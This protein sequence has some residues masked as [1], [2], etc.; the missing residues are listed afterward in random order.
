MSIH[1]K[2]TS[3]SGFSVKPSLGM[4][5]DDYFR[6]IPVFI[7]GESRKGL[8]A[9]KMSVKFD[10]N[11]VYEYIDVKLIKPLYTK[12]FRY[13]TKCLFKAIEKIYDYTFPISYTADGK[14]CITLYHLGLE[15]DYEKRE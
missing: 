15:D 7:K 14:P 10:A 3:A 2:D 9:E 4:L 13:V 1:W 8:K 5:L 12:N 6:V 11:Y